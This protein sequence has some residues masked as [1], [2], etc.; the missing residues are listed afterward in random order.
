VK[1]QTM[2][3]TPDGQWVFPGSGEF[4]AA[5]GD[6][7]PDYDADAFAIKN[8]GFIKF[9][10]I[11]RAIIEIE[12]H[13]RNVALAALLA[14]QQQIQTSDVHLFRIKYFDTAWHSEIT[15]SAEQ[16]IVRLSQLT[17][18]AFVA[19]SRERFI[20]E[21]QDF[22]MLFE[23]EPNQ[24][25]PLAQ[26]WRVS[27]GHFDPSI[28]ALAMRHRLLSRLAIVGVKPRQ[29]D[30][31][32]RFIGDGHR[33][34]GGQY[35]HTGIGQKVANIPDRDYGEWV[36]GF[37]RAVAESGQPRY[38][39]IS[40]SVQY[41]NEPGNPWRP[42]RYDRLL[43]P[44]KTPSDEVFVTMCSRTVGPAATEKPAPAWR[45]DTSDNSLARK[46]AM[47]S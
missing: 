10:M 42:V 45:G 26:K 6:P 5:L 47:S 18:P 15:S 4:L 12:L 9:S 22:A 16:A 35:P 17:A 39:L 36:S 7:D 38:D 1:R 30:P 14:V 8:L 29:Q 21:P 11:E 32:W 27:F 40:T 13:P 23:D 20:V 34:M 43:L 46:F 28:I 33:W 3:V 44:W 19:S 41:R 25:R 24:M 31:V 37:Y 2:L